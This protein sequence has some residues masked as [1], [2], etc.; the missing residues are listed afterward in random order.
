MNTRR[1]LFTVFAVL[2][3]LLPQGMS[4]AAQPANTTDVRI[5]TFNTSD[6]P[7]FDI[8]YTLVGYSNTG[9]DENQDGAVLFADIPYGTYQVEASYPNGSDY[10]VDP[11]TIVVN[12]SSNSFTVTAA[13]NDTT[14][15]DV[16]IWTVTN[17]GEAVYDVCYQLA[18]YSL[19]GCDEN[20]D[21]S[22]LFQD[23]P[24]GTYEVVPSYPNGSNY[25]VAP[26]T[27]VVNA[28]STSF[29]TQAEAQNQ[30]VQQSP[31][32]KGM[33]DVYLITR[34]PETGDALTGA[35]YELVGYSNVGCDENGDGRVSFE[36]I[37]YSTYTIRQVTTPAGYEPMDDY[38]VS[39]MPSDVDGPVSLLLVQQRIQAPKDRY[40]VSVV[41]VDANTG[42][43]VMDPANCAQL[44][45]ESGPIT[46]R[47]CDDGI[48]DGQVDFV[49]VAYDAENGSDVNVALACPYVVAPGAEP[50][51]LWVGQS[52][53]FLYV[54]V[55]DSHKPCN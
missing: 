39:I 14:S 44:R 51:L 55:V 22:V 20:R 46:L 25:R 6:S 7:V 10:Y 36:D 50:Q 8:C 47:G 17:S 29:I 13:P 34:D 12:G 43:L 16:S 21:G 4:L 45:G 54:H 52:S 11:F 37:P 32:M 26:F 40:N 18:G 28:F 49:D 42:K 33:T 5:W 1:L 30:V 48:V 38:I 35:C 3:M 15:V 2:G 31:P 9:C 41:F 23:I 27:I 19:V 53:L 24:F